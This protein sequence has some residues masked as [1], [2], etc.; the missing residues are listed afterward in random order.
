MN[1]IHHMNAFFTQ[2]YDDDRL[3]PTH[4]S[5]YM[6]LFQLWNLNRFK[7][8]MCISRAEVMTIAKIGSAN[9]YSRCINQLHEWKYIDYQPSFNPFRGSVVNLY[10]FDTGTSK[11]SDKGTDNGSVMALRPFIKH[12]KLI[13]HNKQE[14]D[15]DL[16]KNKYDEPL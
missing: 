7:N 3:M 15:N 4:I 13:K 12:N 14:N 8:P 10:S 1:Y 9:T 2:I 16:L 5:L 11:G 6:A